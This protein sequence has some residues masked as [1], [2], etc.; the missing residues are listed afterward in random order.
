LTLGLFG[1]GQ[2]AADGPQF[3]LRSC[4]QCG[5]RALAAGIGWLFSQRAVFLL[6]PVFAVLAAWRPCR[7][8]LGH[9]P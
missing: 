9:R 7:S 8:R 6:V 1:R 3:R 5:D 4:R 2:L